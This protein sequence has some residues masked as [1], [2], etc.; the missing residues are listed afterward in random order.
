MICRKCKKEAPDG[1][2]CIYCGW[3][4]NKQ[5]KSKHRRGNGQGTV[6]KL[7]NGKYQA[8][9]ITAVF[10]DDD[11]KIHRKTR[12]RNFETKKDAVLAI[13][14]L[15]ENPKKEEKKTMTFKQLYDAWLPSHRAG[16]STMDC[17]KSAVKYFGP[18]FHMKIADI[19]VDD[20]Q[21]CMDSC[22]KGKRTKE[23]MRAVCGLVYK[24]GIP[25]KVIPDNLNLAPFLIIDGDSAAH[26]E[27]FTENQIEL[28]RKA[29]GTVP[30]AEDVY[31]MI[32]TGFRPSEFLAL[33]SDSYDKDRNCLIGGSKT[34]AGINRIVTVSPKIRNYVEE[35]ARNDG[36]LFGNN[37]KPYTLQNFTD[38]VFYP[39]L[40]AAG[41]D[42]P[43]VEIAGG[44]KRHKYTPHSCRHTFATLLKRI[45]GSDKD[46][47]ELIGHSSSEM[48]RYYQDVDLSD[49]KKITDLL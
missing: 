16:K 25:R 1:A 36:S 10:V 40:E 11:G 41:I 32:Y 42:N 34:Q 15:L 12:S 26:R 33:T 4:Q 6:Y 37:G 43:M 3:N 28:I 44:V 22:P 20:L 45:S 5:L 46:K 9:V 38:A 19:D 21:E 18:V 49:L 47:Q 14:S 17:Y 39:V 31:C 13:P 23:N 8:S 29:C 7:P 24:Y 35:K 30:H 27:S 2:F 48:L